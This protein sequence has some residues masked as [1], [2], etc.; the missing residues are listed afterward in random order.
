MAV[1]TLSKTPEKIV[2]VLEIEEIDVSP[3]DITVIQV[4]GIVLVLKEALSLAV[5]FD[6]EGQE[7]VMEYPE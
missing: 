3:M 1:L 4:D 2:G 5:S 6:P 7:F